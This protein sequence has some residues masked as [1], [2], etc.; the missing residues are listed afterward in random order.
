[1]SMADLDPSRRDRE[2]DLS[3]QRLGCASPGAVGLLSGL[4]VEDMHRK[5]TN[6]GCMLHASGP[7]P[8]CLQG[9][10]SDTHSGGRERRGGWSSFR[11]QTTDTLPS[12]KAICHLC[13][14]TQDMLIKCPRQTIS[15]IGRCVGDSFVG[16]HDLSPGVMQVLR[17]RHN[18]GEAWSRGW[19]LGSSISWRAAVA[20]GWDMYQSRQWLFMLG[21]CVGDISHAQFSHFLSCGQP[22]QRTVSTETS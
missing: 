12:D 13:T 16:V 21:L 8:I 3:P 9:R 11:R 15:R 10:A 19:N 20:S 6:R 4:S 14:V 18:Y 7:T 5:G 22:Q 2:P 17:G 1:M